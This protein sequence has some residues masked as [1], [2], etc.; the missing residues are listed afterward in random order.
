[1]SIEIVTH[2]YA[3][4]YPHFAKCLQAQLMS[5]RYNCSFCAVKITVCCTES[6]RA[7]IDVLEDEGDLVSPLFMP[8][9]ELGRRAVGRN[10]VALFTAADIVWFADV[11]HLFL[12]GML[13][14]LNELEW[15]DDTSMLYPKEIMI[16]RDHVVG[17]RQLDNVGYGWDSFFDFSDF[18][19][20]HYHKAIGGVQ[21]VTGDFARTHGYLN[22]TKWMTC[23]NKVPFGDFKDDIAYR[24]FC[25]QYGKIRGIDLSGVFRLR[26]TTTSYQ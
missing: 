2:C 3:Q 17:D 24:G 13:D 23:F 11:D 25:S 5:I 8:V 18:I 9:R 26:H 4:K 19:L 20:K 6:D 12:D 22:N 15:P 21:I 14:Y 1:M 16:S 7:T 10:R